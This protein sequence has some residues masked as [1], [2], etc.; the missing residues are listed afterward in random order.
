M[1]YKGHA[2]H[3]D[4]PSGRS[5]GTVSVSSQY[6]SFRLSKR[7]NDSLSEEVQGPVSE[8]VQLP[9][10]GLHIEQGGA[11]NRVIFFS[12]DAHPDWKLYTTDRDILRDPN[13]KDHR[14]VQGRSGYRPV[15]LDHS[16]V[17]CIHLDQPRK[18]TTAEVVERSVLFLLIAKCC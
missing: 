1:E 4:L 13:L 5:S 16:W 11:Q 12:H 14:A 2:F 10:S 3:S 6:I 7:L 9:I 15:R 17:G 18:R 8:E